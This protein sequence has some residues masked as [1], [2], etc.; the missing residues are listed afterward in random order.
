[1]APPSDVAE[2]IVW[3]V[4]RRRSRLVI[5]SVGRLTR[6]LYALAPGLYE[7]MMTRSL[8]SESRGI[9]PGS[10][11]HSRNLRRTIPAP[12]SP[13]EAMLEDPIVQLAGLVVLAFAVTWLG[14]RA[15]VPVILPLLVTGFLIGPVF[16]LANP[17]ELLGDLL[18]PAVSIAVGL[19]LFEGGLSLRIREMEGQ[20][21]VLWLLV[22]VGVLIT[23][24]IGAIVTSLFTDLFHRNGHP[25]RID[26]GGLRTDGDRAPVDPGPTKSICGVDP[27][28]GEHHH[29][30]RSV[31]CWQ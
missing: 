9:G 8:R 21:R 22:T 6:Y 11:G 27:Q 3:A 20:Q 16:G 26:P 30:T 25:R 28:V 18:A 19:I 2:R 10:D 4:E 31:P 23:W 17:D 29:R 7:R 1:M 5:G 12:P 13:K 24:L 15:R 14:E